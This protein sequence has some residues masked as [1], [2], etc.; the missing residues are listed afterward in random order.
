MLL[1]VVGEGTE[2]GVWSAVLGEGGCERLVETGYGHANGSDGAVCTVFG[3]AGVFALEFV[4]LFEFGEGFGFFGL[5][6]VGGV[7]EGFEF[8]LFAVKGAHGLAVIKGEAAFLEAST[9]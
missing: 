8:L 9:T 6:G 1:D 2:G 7:E 5:G 4:D 3:T